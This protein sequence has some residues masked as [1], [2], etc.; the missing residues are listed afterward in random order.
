MLNI[1]Q[2]ELEVRQLW[3]L[4]VNPNLRSPLPL[5]MSATGTT[6]PCASFAFVIKTCAF[7]SRKLLLLLLLLQTMWS[8]LRCSGRTSCLLE[9]SPAS[10]FEEPMAWRVV[11]LLS[12]GPSSSEWSGLPSS[13]FR[14]VF[15]RV[16]RVALVRVVSH[17]HQWGQGWSMG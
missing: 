9:W 2:L 5:P 13:V 10:P 14:V 12:S 16:F 15:I 6:V 11:L 17:P 8:H 1:I 4:S 7:Q 3:R